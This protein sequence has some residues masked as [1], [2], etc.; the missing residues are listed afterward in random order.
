[1]HSTRDVNQ[2]IQN[3]TA[4]DTAR[5]NLEKYGLS[6][7]NLSW[8]RTAAQ[9]AL[10]LKLHGILETTGYQSVSAKLQHA[11]LPKFS[12]IGTFS[13]GD[14][15]R[16]THGEVHQKKRKE[17][18]NDSED[19]FE[20]GIV[21]VKSNLD[22]EAHYEDNGHGYDMLPSPLP[23]PERSALCAGSVL[24][25]DLTPVEVTPSPQSIYNLPKETNQSRVRYSDTSNNDEAGALLLGDVAVDR[26][27]DRLRDIIRTVDASLSKCLSSGLCFGAE[28]C[29]KTSIQLDFLREIDN[30]E[31]WRGK[32]IGQRALLKGVDSLEITRE[33]SLASTESF[34]SGKLWYHLVL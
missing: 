16:T 9:A 34:V 29:E 31:G 2:L 6:G 23:L 1:M 27:I 7:G 32:M 25:K 15:E 30:G 12:K 22:E 17:D 5:Y 8:V 21:C 3:G 10:A 20:K 11:S 13:T 18:V 26:D 4:I 28:T 14:E 24:P 33:A 19:D